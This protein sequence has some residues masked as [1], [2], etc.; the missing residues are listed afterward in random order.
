MSAKAEFGTTA[1]LELQ[2]LGPD[3]NPVH[4][5]FGIDPSAILSEALSCWSVFVDSPRGH[6]TRGYVWW[7]CN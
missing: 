2:S 5:A 1:E 4:L 3:V 7:E 6:L